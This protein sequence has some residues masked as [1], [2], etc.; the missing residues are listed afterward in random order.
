MSKL[1]VRK[2]ETAVLVMDYQNFVFEAVPQAREQGIV[3]RA[4][5]VL[6]AARTAGLFIGYVARRYRDGY[7]E[8]G[9]RDPR[10]VA[11]KQAGH[12]REGT[13]GAEVVAEVAPVTGEPVFVKKRTSAFLHTDLDLTL[14]AQGIRDIVLLGVATSGVVLST[15]RVA[16]DLDYGVVVLEDCC[17][18][19]N[20]EVHNCLMKYVLPSQAT[21]ASSEEFIKALSGN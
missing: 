9:T 3:Q 17:V 11:Y 2:A 20:P 4:Q 12:L 19:R 18:D 10:L 6:E 21:V 15:V 13:K 16:A 8:V 1:L 5:R 7:P 14:R